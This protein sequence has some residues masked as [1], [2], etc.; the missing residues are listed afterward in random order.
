MLHSV[1]RNPAAQ[2][3]DMKTQTAIIALAT[4]LFTAPAFAD[5]NRTDEKGHWAEFLATHTI[6]TVKTERGEK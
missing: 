3:I 5:H 1:A 4:V 2:R 6:Q